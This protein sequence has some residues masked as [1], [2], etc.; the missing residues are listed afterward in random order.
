M[1]QLS[2]TSIVE[3][4]ALDER[5][6]AMVEEFRNLARAAAWRAFQRSPLADLDELVSI[7]YTGLVEACERYPRY[8]A[9]H[10][11][12]P[13]NTDYVAAY[14]SR[15]VNGALLDSM[16]S[17]D[18]ITRAD[19]NI[20][21]ALAEAENLGLD[22]AGQ[23]KFAGV[24]QRKADAVRAAEARKPM[25]LDPPGEDGKFADTLPD[26][27]D[28]ESSVVVGS[29]LGAAMTVIRG[30]DGA[31]QWLVVLVHYYAMKVD[32]AAEVLG[33]DVDK[34]RELYET[35]IVAAYEGMLRAAS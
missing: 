11:F 32:Q 16:R 25:S 15:R 22:R 3:F 31:N 12:D 19:R 10:H 4:V 17:A 2:A 1:P 28:I 5:G 21:K 18:H 8:V 27:T 29:V 33:L 20:S 6:K 7:A 34:A 14:I 9:E 24:D 35:A 13:A 26:E 23:A 30:L